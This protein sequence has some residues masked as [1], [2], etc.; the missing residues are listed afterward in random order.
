MNCLLQFDASARQLITGSDFVHR[1]STFWIGPFALV[2]VINIGTSPALAGQTAKR[3]STKSKSSA[4]ASQNRTAYSAV[5][6][7][8]TSH[9]ADRRADDGDG[10]R[11]GR[12]APA[13]QGRR[14]RRP[15]S[16][17]PRCC[18]DR[19]RPG[20][21]PGPLGGK[22][23]GPAIDR[24]HHEGDDGDGVPRKRSRSV[25]AGDHCAQRRVP[26]VDHAS[27]SERQSHDRRSPA[28]SAHRVGQRGRAR[29][30]A[31]VGLWLGGIRP[32]DERESR[33][34]LGF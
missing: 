11:D 17:Y 4:Q 31:R 15:R 3:S 30:G 23:S 26:G 6:S 22:L 25:R 18:R 27:A 12:S 32:A 28:S 21:Q 5:R 16:R 1:K 8:I 29:A 7:Q 10:P 13:L 20:N 34:N 33:R 14:E 19:V 24:Q 9:Q 2:A